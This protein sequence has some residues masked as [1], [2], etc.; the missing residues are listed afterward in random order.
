MATIRFLLILDCSSP[1]N[2]GLTVVDTALDI[3]FCNELK[4]KFLKN[5]LHRSNNR[6]Y[7]SH[8]ANS[9]DK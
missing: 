2:W 1:L 5:N 7:T 9:P 3:L 8:I 4:I 6:G